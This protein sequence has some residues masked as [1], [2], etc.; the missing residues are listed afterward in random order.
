M[1]KRSILTSIGD[2]FGD[3][4]RANHATATYERLSAMSDERLAARGLKRGDIAAAAFETAFR[5]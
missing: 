4:R 5:I 2:I 1:A 3:I